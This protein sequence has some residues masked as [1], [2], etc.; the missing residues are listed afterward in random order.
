MTVLL[1]GKQGAQRSNLNTVDIVSNE[2]IGLSSDDKPE[3]VAEGSTYHSVDTGE[4][5]VYHDL[6]WE[7]DYSKVWAMKVAF[8]LQ[9]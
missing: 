9:G 3:N 2:Y 1:S 4:C 8:G 5:W 7:I 6:M